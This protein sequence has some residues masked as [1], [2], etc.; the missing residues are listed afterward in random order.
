AANSDSSENSPPAVDAGRSP[1]P[2]W[3]AGPP[4]AGRAVSARATARQTGSSAG[5]AP[6]SGSGRQPAI[7]TQTPGQ[8]GGASRAGAASP[9]AGQDRGQA[10]DRLLVGVLEEGR[11]DARAEL[12]QHGGA[13]AGGRGGRR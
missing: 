5:A 2:T 1:Q 8:S 6:G 10:D 13:Q 4:L 7:T 12:G 11:R 9:D 3:T